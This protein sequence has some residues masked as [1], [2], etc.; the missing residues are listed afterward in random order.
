MV[1]QLLST[2]FLLGL[3][4]FLYLC[5]WNITQNNK[6][7]WPFLKCRH[8][9]PL[10]QGVC[11]S[12]RDRLRWQKPFFT[13]S[14]LSWAIHLVC[15][16]HHMSPTAT[17]AWTPPPSICCPPE[18]W[19]WFPCTVWNSDSPGRRKGWDQSP[20]LPGVSPPWPYTSKCWDLWAT[21]PWH[22]FP[23]QQHHQEPRCPWQRVFLNSLQAVL[24]SQANM[25]SIKWSWRNAEKKHVV[26][27]CI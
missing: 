14:Y 5:S 26:C 15:S 12:E 19:A 23:A 3:E 4:Q 16:H 11:T 6:F 21:V 20:S 7:S 1:G 13:N 8:P 27:T 22:C 24:L 10:P 2:I 25:L 9:C 17:V 18:E